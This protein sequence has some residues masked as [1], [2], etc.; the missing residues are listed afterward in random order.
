[1]LEMTGCLQRAILE[2]VMNWKVWV[3]A[4]T[5]VVA[6]GCGGSGGELT[7]A[8]ISDIYDACEDGGC[9]QVADRLIDASE[10][11]G[12]CD[13]RNIAS[14]LHTRAYKGERLSGVGDRFCPIDERSFWTK[15]RSLWTK[16]WKLLAGIGSGLLL[17]WIA[18]DAIYL[19]RDYE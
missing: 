1:M 4:L 10:Q 18:V 14:I 6:L 19:A 5:V 15:Q 12:S 3:S 16:H 13:F 7:S 17:L 9:L 11:G 2:G 8:E